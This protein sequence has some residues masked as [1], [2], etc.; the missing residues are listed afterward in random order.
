MKEIIPYLKYGFL[1]AHGIVGA[2]KFWKSWNDKTCMMRCD[3]IGDCSLEFNAN[4]N[5]SFLVSMVSE[6]PWY[7]NFIR[8]SEEV[9][10]D[11]NEEGMNFNYDERVYKKITIICKNDKEFRQILNKYHGIQE[12]IQ[13]DLIN[14][15][16]TLRAYEY[17]RNINEIITWTKHSRIIPFEQGIEYQ[18]WDEYTLTF[19]FQ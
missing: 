10:G 15:M 16:K 9:N 2:W 7:M 19:T 5:R 13:S 14:Y 18:Y 11:R 4:E 12:V 3:N 8:V 17:I 1:F 6:P